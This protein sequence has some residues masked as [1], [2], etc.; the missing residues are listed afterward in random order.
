MGLAHGNQACSSQGIVPELALWMKSAQQS[1]DGHPAEGQDGDFD[2]RQ[3]QRCRGGHGWDEPEP[4]GHI[5]LE[6]H[7]VTYFLPPCVHHFNAPC[8]H[9][10]GLSTVP[11]PD[12]IHA[13]HQKT[14][15]LQA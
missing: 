9:G 10:Q 2:D 5:A 1:P 3:M 8:F 15:G 14:D 13:Q 11:H 7:F 12:E 4:A 6:S